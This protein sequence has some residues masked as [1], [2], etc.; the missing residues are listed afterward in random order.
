MGFD[1]ISLSTASVA[2]AA[3]KY[4]EQKRKARPAKPLEQEKN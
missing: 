2:F 1:T 3:E 4:R